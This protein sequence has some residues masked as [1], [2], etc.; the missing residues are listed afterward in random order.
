MCFINYSSCGG[1][2][3]VCVCVREREIP[4]LCAWWWC[5]GSWAVWSEPKAAP[6]W[7]WA[8]G[9]AAGSPC[10]YWWNCCTNPGCSVWL[11]NTQENA[12]L[13]NVFAANRR[14]CSLNCKANQISYSW[15]WSGTWVT[16]GNGSSW[17]QQ[18]YMH[19]SSFLCSAVAFSVQHSLQMLILNI[20]HLELNLKCHVTFTSNCTLGHEKTSPFSLQ[21]EHYDFFFFGPTIFLSQPVTHAETHNSEFKASCGMIGN[22]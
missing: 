9:W 18:L 3:F 19:Y 7:G 2:V 14:A 21:T 16:A 12:G 5:P 13:L 8:M 20:A 6:Q 22:N 10:C 1:G 17:N 15:I 4:T 11:E